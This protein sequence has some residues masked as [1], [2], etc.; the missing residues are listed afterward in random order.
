MSVETS[1]SKATRKALLTIFSVWLAVAP[2]GAAAV[3]L[4]PDK[5]DWKEVA[6]S[7]TGPTQ[8]LDDYSVKISSVAA[9]EE[10]LTVYVQAWDAYGAPVGF[11]HDGS[12]ETERFRFVGDLPLYY[13]DYGQ[14]PTLERDDDGHLYTKYPEIYDP[15]VAFRR[16]LEHTIS[17]V[18]RDGS[19]IVKGKIGNTTTTVYPDADPE[20]S[21]V[22]GRVERLSVDEAWATIRSGNGNSATDNCTNCAAAA[23]NVSA[24]TN[25]FQ[26]IRRGQFVFDTSAVSTDV[27][28]SATFSLYGSSKYDTGVD[29]PE[30]CVVGGNTGSDTALAAAD[31]QATGTTEWATNRITYANWDTA[32]YNDFTLNSTGES[33][34]NGSGN[35][36]IAAILD[37]DLDNVAPTW[38]SGYTAGFSPFHADNG[39]N[40]PKLVVVHTALNTCGDSYIDGGEA[41]DDGDTDN[42]DGCSSTCTVESGWSCVGEPSVCT[43]DAVSLDEW[44]IP[45]SPTAFDAIAIAAY[46]FSY[47]IFF[48][49]A[50]LKL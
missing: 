9:T 3:S 39:S 29:A 30:L 33:N 44:E 19:N 36:D 50:L 31:Y 28:R 16:Q 21:T 49:F 5:Q 11:G 8:V 23:Y 27:V 35:T 32:G 15:L 48:G 47:V 37:F 25:Q 12:V 22:D 7:L 43:E 18:A 45:A 14:L 10:E 4:S 40:K 20:S 17:V 41:C 26:N 46:F 13:I 38:G 2:F 6:E 34:I 42:G 24:T 1:Q